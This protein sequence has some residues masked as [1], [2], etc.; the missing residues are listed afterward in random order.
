M[1]SV[2][3]AAGMHHVV[4]C[5]MLTL[6]LN[7][8]VGKKCIALHNVPTLVF[9]WANISA[10]KQRAFLDSIFDDWDQPTMFV[11]LLNRTPKGLAWSHANL[12]PFGLLGLTSATAKF[13]G[14][15]YPQFNTL[16][17]L[18][19]K[20][21]SV[22]GL[23]VDGTAIQVVKPYKVGS[24]KKLNLRL[25][26][27]PRSASA[28]ATDKTQLTPDTYRRVFR[29]LTSVTGALFQLKAATGLYPNQ[30]KAKREQA[31]ADAGLKALA[32]SI[33]D[34]AAFAKH[35]SIK[36]IPALYRRYVATINWGPA[37]STRARKDQRFFEVV[38]PLAEYDSRVLSK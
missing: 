38:T 9:H 32:A 5:A 19:V 30:A 4:R 12:V 3:I 20:T 10:A 15:D 6:N 13:N 2:Q 37:A 21:S 33:A 25:A 16:L 17:L 24:L 34:V 1:I 23:D 28:K 14:S 29:A 35:P 18:D 26:A 31:K 7:D 8:F 27:E 11:G 22:V 36:K